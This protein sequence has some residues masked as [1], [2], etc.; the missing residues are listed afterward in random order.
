[1]DNNVKNK[2]DSETPAFI[3]VTDSPL[4]TLTSEQKVII[5]RKGNEL[6]NEKKY[7]EAR[8]LFITTGYSD[9]LT[10]LGDVEAKNNRELDALKLY[11]LAHNKRKTE[12][13]IEKLSSLISMLL[14][15][16]KDE[17]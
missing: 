14:E 2:I 8:R 5:N 12:P 17:K 3:K 6:F 15:D 10:R 13:L 1:M 16:E 11:Y 7:D 9:G 4:S